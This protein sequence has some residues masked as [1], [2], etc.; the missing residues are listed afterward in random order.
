M[1]PS[2]STMPSLGNNDTSPATDTG[3]SSMDFALGSFPLPSES[4]RMSSKRN[5]RRNNRQPASQNWTS[6]FTTPEPFPKYFVI[7]SLQGSKLTALNIFAV[8]RAIRDHLGSEPAKITPHRDGNF[9]IEVSSR[10]QS[11]KLKLLT[12]LVGE[13]VKVDKHKTLNTSRGVITSPLLRGLSEE[14]VVDG[15]KDRG[16]IG[17]YRITRRAPDGEGT[18]PTDSLVLTF[19]QTTLPD[20][21]RIIAGCYVKV[22]PYIPLPRRCF[23]CHR[24]AHVGK[25]CRSLTS[26]CV[27]CGQVSHDDGACTR[28]PHCINCNGPHPASSRDCPSYKEEKEILTL[29]ALHKLSPRE[30]RAAVLERVGR[31]SFSYAVA[32]KPASQV[33]G[34]TSRMSIPVA[35]SA[36][37]LSP[38]STTAVSSLTGQST[39]PTT[40]SV[41]SSSASSSAAGSA[42]PVRSRARPDHSEKPPV[43]LPAR[44][45]SSP[46]REKPSLNHVSPARQSIKRGVKSPTVP[47]GDKKPR[48]HTT[49]PLTTEPAHFRPQLSNRYEVLSTVDIPLPSTRDAIPIALPQP[50]TKPKPSSSGSGQRSL[51]LNRSSEPPSRTNSCG[52]A[53]ISLHSKDASQS[54]RRNARQP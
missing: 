51:S 36:I 33:D 10:Q 50:Q 26:F 22:K 12:K 46:A 5:Q 34:K 8:D 19:D 30:A 25:H 18:L 32:T 52:G 15:L 2:T 48:K 39:V 43:A 28:D 42:T 24:Y 11:D 29:V 53:D 14:D 41:S 13:G 44:M 47:A 27:T 16:V 37:R 3:H 21:L 17:A 1:M 4:A 38:P 35:N 20:S 49:F 23:R 54:G 9:L 40:T 31:N 7:D 45:E 6:V